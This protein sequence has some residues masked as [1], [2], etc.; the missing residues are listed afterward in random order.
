MS[1]SI[2]R[3]GLVKFAGKYETRTFAEEVDALQEHG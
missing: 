2:D 1:F 3:E